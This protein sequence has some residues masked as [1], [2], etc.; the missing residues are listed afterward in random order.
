MRCRKEDDKNL[1]STYRAICRHSMVNLRDVISTPLRKNKVHKKLI[2][3]VTKKVKRKGKISML[4]CRLQKI[5]NSNNLSVREKQ[6]LTRMYKKQVKEGSINWESML[7]E[8]PGKTLIYVQEFCKDIKV[9]IHSDFS[10]IKSED[11]KF[12]IALYESATKRV[13][14]RVKEKDEEEKEER[15][16]IP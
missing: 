3:E 7:H 2:L 11:F 10:V 1:F 4:V 13:F 12:N 6:D 9:K 15:D 5:F 16:I 14:K 8:F